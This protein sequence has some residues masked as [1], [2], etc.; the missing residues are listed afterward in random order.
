MTIGR[1]NNSASLTRASTCW[2]VDVEPTIGTNCFGMLSRE[3][4]HRRVPV[5]PHMIIGTIRASIRKGPSL[6]AATVQAVLAQNVKPYGNKL[7]GRSTFRQSRPG[8]GQNA[9]IRSDFSPGSVDDPGR[10]LGLCHVV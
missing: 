3:T 7:E 5:P 6:T 10:R 4:G 1:A 2:K 8:D 9:I